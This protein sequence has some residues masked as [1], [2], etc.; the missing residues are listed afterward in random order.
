MQYRLST[1]LVAFVVVWASL[2]VF[3][4][5]GGIV[6]AA[7]LLVIAAVVRRPGARKSPRLGWIAF[8]VGFSCWHCCCQQFI[9]LWMGPGGPGALGT[10][11]ILAWH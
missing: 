11:R 2:A 3:G 6:A 8:L 7:I 1:L 9:S 5:A 4:V 10:S